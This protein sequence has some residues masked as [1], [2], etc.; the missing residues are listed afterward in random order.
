[1]C[2]SV[3]M[4]SHESGNPWAMAVLQGGDLSRAM[5]SP[6]HPISNG[7]PGCNLKSFIINTLEKSPEQSIW[8]QETSS[9]NI[10]ELLLN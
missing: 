4:I 3:I 2:T 8:R 6:S 9:N 10:L 5:H 7:G 1:M